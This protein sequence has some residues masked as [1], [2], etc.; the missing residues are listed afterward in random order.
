[1]AR[2]AHTG[3]PEP[4][5]D[6]APVTA[7]KDTREWFEPAVEPEPTPIY[8]GL[9][10]DLIERRAAAANAAAEKETGR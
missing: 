1:M 5:K 4:R 2:R 3:P 7:E 8:D 6:T 9:L 10:A